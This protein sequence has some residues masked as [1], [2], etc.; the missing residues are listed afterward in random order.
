MWRCGGRG[1][2]VSDFQPTSYSSVS[3]AVSWLREAAGLEGREQIWGVCRRS[4]ERM[5]L[6]VRLGLRVSM[7]GSRGWLWVSVSEVAPEEGQGE[8]DCPEAGFEDIG[9]EWPWTQSPTWI[10][11][12]GSLDVQIWISGRYSR[13]ESFWKWALWISPVVQWLGLCASTAGGMGSIPGRGTEILHVALRGQKKNSGRYPQWAHSQRGTRGRSTAGV[14]I[15][16]LT[17]WGA[18]ALQAWTAAGL[19]GEL[20]RGPADGTEASS[21][22]PWRAHFEK[23]KVASNF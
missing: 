23:E 13:L 18:A 1:S 8:G 15:T 19:R 21:V 14:E 20:S 2:W 12:L 11:P 6:L 7:L 4:V 10:C 16:P 3:P 5:V 22:E 17:T 9:L